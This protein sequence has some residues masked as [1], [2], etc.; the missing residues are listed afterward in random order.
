MA[1]VSLDLQ[2]AKLI[3]AYLDDASSITAGVPATTVCPRVIAKAGTGEE[4][5]VYAR[6]AASV[7]TTGRTAQIVVS[8]VVIGQVK[9]DTTAEALSALQKKIY[10]RLSDRTSFYVWLAAQPEADR[11][12]FQIM[13]YQLP[14]I[15]DVELQPG[16][17]LLQSAIL[18]PIHVALW[19]V[20]TD[21]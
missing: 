2:F 3:K 19:K 17:K 7:N 5:S 14:S 4:K 6:I 21:A 10:D 16:D 1:N 8:I 18:L 20:T 9:G 15:V 13:K 11:T 12:G